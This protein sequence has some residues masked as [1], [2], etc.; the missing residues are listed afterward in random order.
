MQP[1]TSLR[2][3]GFPFISYVASSYKSTKEAASDDLCVSFESQQFVLAV[4]HY[5]ANSKSLIKC[6][7]CKQVN[8][9]SFIGLRSILCKPVFELQVFISK[10]LVF[11]HFSGKPDWLY[12]LL[13]LV[14]HRYN[15]VNTNLECTWSLKKGPFCLPSF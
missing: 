13:V 14:V 2:S 6:K 5:V 10:S 4:R 11:Q 9:I 7:A 8:W 1:S 12:C 15:F 3:L